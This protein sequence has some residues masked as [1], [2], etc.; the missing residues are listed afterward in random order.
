MQTKYKVK[1]TEIMGEVYY[2]VMIWRRR[3]MTNRWQVHERFASEELA[4]NC[5]ELMQDERWC[6]EQAG[7]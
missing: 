2:D 1:K 7:S 5:M 4:R 6:R 3:N